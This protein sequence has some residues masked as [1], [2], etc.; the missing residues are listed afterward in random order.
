MASSVDRTRGP[1][2]SGPAPLEGGSSLRVDVA[3][4]GRHPAR[5]PAG[6]GGEFRGRNLGLTGERPELMDVQRGYYLDILV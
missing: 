5:A 1:G 4:S 6:S 3:R 2:S